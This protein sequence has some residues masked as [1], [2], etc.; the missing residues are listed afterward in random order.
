MIKGS[1]ILLRAPRQRCATVAK[2]LTKAR[3]RT[4]ESR[5]HHGRTL[6][7]NRLRAR[8]DAFHAARAR[9][10]LVTRLYARAMGEDHPTDVAASGSCDMPLLGPTAARL[11]M[12]P[13]RLLTDAGCGT[14]GIGLWLARALALRLDGFDCS[15]V[16]VARAGTRRHVFLGARAGRA[17]FRV[18][19][20]EDTGCPTSLPTASCVWTSS[21]APPARTRCCASSP[22][23]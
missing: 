7:G 8:Y 15:P 20:P 14:G 17:V 12:R 4:D 11:R 18:A 23:S 19:E 9:T 22:A 13:G 6:P 1:D 3:A 10:D 5:P 21:A 2:R 16:A